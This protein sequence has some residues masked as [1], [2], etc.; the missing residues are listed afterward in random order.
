VVDRDLLLRKLADLD[1]YVGQVSEFRTVTSDEYRRDWKVQRIVERT[2]QMAIEA[3]LDVAN[4]VVADRQLRVA[5]TYAEIF[6]V[7][8]EAGLLEPSLRNAMIRM[9][10]FRNILVHDY[11]VHDYERIDP[12]VVLRILRDDLEDFRRFRQAALGWI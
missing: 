8:G 12:A 10:R 3:C 6:D 1:E 2:L 9:T 5:A 4:H 7:L 11:V